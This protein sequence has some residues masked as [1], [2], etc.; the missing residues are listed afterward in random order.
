MLTKVCD[1]CSRP[2]GDAK[3]DFEPPLIYFKK[4][5]DICSECQ[6][7]FIKWA[8][9]RKDGGKKPCLDFAEGVRGIVKTPKV[10]PLCFLIGDEVIYE[11]HRYLVTGVA[12]DK[13]FICGIS[14]ESRIHINYEMY[15][16][17]KTGR[18]F[19]ILEQIYDELE[20]GGHYETNE[21]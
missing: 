16:V 11:N 12:K 5:I 10:S 4:E 7:S 1:I 17:V 21:R 8:D 15:P 14:R 2:M 18:T 13:P 19:P 3:R 9:S 20:K 6:K